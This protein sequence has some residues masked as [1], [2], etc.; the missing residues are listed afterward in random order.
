MQAA[1]LQGVQNEEPLTQ[2]LGQVR[3]GTLNPEPLTQGQVRHGTLNPEP[4][5]QDMEP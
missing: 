2:A 5:T 1:M 3:H 4:L